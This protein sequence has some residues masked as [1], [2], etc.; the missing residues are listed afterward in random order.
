PLAVHAISIIASIGIGISFN[1]NDILT[2]P[3]IDHPR[4]G[5]AAEA[6][7][8]DPEDT[9]GLGRCMFPH[10][11]AL[12]PNDPFGRKESG[13]PRCPGLI[14]TSPTEHPAHERRTPGIAFAQVRIAEVF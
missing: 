9:A 11:L 12:L 1:S 14:V 10:S 13:C 4:M 2:V 3:L 7:E 5:D 6:A 8:P